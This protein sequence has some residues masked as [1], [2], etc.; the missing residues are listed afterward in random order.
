MAIVAVDG[1]LFV[2]ALPLDGDELKEGGA[3]SG[4]GVVDG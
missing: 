1:G 3:V 2:S 4:G